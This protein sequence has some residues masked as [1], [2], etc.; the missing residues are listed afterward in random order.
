[1]TKRTRGERLVD[2][3]QTEAALTRPVMV[4]PANDVTIGTDKSAYGIQTILPTG[5]VGTKSPN[6]IPAISNSNPSHG[7][8]GA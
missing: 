4:C 7:S 3:R 5:A 6:P 1:V 8:D 2:R